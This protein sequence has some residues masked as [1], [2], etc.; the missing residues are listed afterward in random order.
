[1]RYSHAKHLIGDTIRR[2]ASPVR[3]EGSNT[4]NLGDSTSSLNSSASEESG[5]PT[6]LPL[7]PTSRPLLHSFSTNDANLN[8]FRYTVTVGTHAIKITGD[9]LNIVNVSFILMRNK[10]TDSILCRIKLNLMAV[11]KLVFLFQMAKLV[12]DDYFENFNTLETPV[13]EFGDVFSFNSR[14]S[15]DSRGILGSQDY[16]SNGSEDTVRAN[17][18]PSPTDD[19][20]FIKNSSGI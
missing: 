9:N 1:M 5:R 4:G 3:L 13:S 12:L 16:N 6:L 15:L 8:E 17:G 7:T 19:D 2:N 11:I 20:V 10:C 18:L 14:Q